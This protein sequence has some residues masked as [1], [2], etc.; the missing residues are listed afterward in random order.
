MKQKLLIESQKLKKIQ[1]YFYQN[2]IHIA[3]KK[4]K[5]CILI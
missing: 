4:I 5:Q 1:D 3:K 2:Y